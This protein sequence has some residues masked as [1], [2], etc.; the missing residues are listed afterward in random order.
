MCI[1]DSLIMDAPEGLLY[2]F[3]LGNVALENFLELGAAVFQHTRDDVAEEIFLQ[4]HQLVQVHV[5]NLGL[6][7]PEL[8]EMAARLGFLGAKRR[9][10]TVHLAERSD[11]RLVVEL[12]ALREI[13][14]VSEVIRLE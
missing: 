1:R 9:S 3:E 2:G 13:R 10:E 7:H 6:H 12:S 14:L 8:G 5:R 4:L 11:G